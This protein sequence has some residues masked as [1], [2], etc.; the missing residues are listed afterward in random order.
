LGAIGNATL[1][2]IGIINHGR[3]WWSSRFTISAATDGTDAVTYD[4]SLT[5]FKHNGRIYIARISAT[6][7]SILTM[8]TLIS[9][10]GGLQLLDAAGSVRSAKIPALDEMTQMTA[11]EIN[12]GEWAS[13]YPP[14]ETELWELRFHSSE[15]DAEAPPTYSVDLQVLYRLIEGGL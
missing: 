11:T 8:P 13:P 2:Q 6:A 9:R 7:N 1:D 3:G 14:L 12:L 4:L 5:E 15:I 10:R